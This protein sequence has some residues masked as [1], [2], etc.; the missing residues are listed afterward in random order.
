MKNLYSSVYLVSRIASALVMV[1]SVALFTRLVDQ[2]T[3]G[4]YLIG[5]A[6]AFILYSITTQWILGAHFGQQSRE[7]AAQVAAGALVMAGLA[8]IVGL[9][10]LGGTVL[11]GFISLDVAA[12]AGVL[13]VGFTAYFLAAEIGR[14]Q[15]LVLPVTLASTVR[16]V[17]TLVL[18]GL[19]LW[20][21][22]SA[23]S[24]LIAA[25]VSHILAG[26]VVFVALQRRGIW[27]SGFALRDTATYAR[28]WRYGWPLIVAGG[29]AAIATLADRLMLEHFY[30]PGLVGSYGATLD[31]IKQS[32]V[33][34]GETVAVAYVSRA[35]YQH[36]DGMSERARESLKQAFISASFLATF[37]MVFY[38]LL[39][40]KVF[41]LLLDADYHDALPL[42]PILAAAS[43]CLVLRSY[44]FGQAIY[45][46]SSV[47]L[48]L[49]ST[50]VALVVSLALSWW[51][52]PLYSLAGAAVAFA[53]AQLAALSVFLLSPQARRL[54]P[55]DAPRLLTL[56]LVAGG[57][58]IVGEA[59]RQTLGDAAIPLNL[60]LIALA[61]ATL[62][63]RWD[64]FDA[65]RVWAGLRRVLR[66]ARAPR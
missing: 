2:D 44:Y 47:R 25:G 14:A 63:V 24:L 22:K 17:G 55:V 46:T 37:G 54:M 21:F 60:V 64:M 15:L 16:S 31:F 32:F 45:F 50:L 13:L 38:L 39:G 40:D 41:G 11:T 28:L 51:L 65:G 56:L 35:K 49:I 62:L 7:Q 42:V 23:A 34:V 61:S 48:E 52:I 26:L 1:L 4:Q 43:A 12:P 66:E 5:F 18:G 8:T 3:Y 58:L 30:S 36:G 57:V 19:A 20:Y 33:M 10:L 29:A 9:C 59:M 6:F 27:A 53:V